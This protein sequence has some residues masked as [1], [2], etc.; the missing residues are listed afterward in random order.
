MTD[1]ADTRCALLATG[2]SP[3][4][5]RGKKPAF[6]EWQKKVETNDAEIRLW[7][8]MWPND[9]HGHPYTVHTGD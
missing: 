1:P 9:E 3:L 2:F 6:D 5:L 4:P 7:G 8:L